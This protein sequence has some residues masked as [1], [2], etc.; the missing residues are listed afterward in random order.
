MKLPKM[1]FQFWEA[2]KRF[3]KL[4]AQL[5]QKE[6]DQLNRSAVE[7]LKKS[8]IM[9]MFLSILLTIFKSLKPS[10]TQ[11]DHEHLVATFVYFIFSSTSIYFISKHPSYVQVYLGFINCTAFIM[12]HVSYV[13]DYVGHQNCY[14]SCSYCSFYFMTALSPSK[15]R[16]NSIVF[17]LTTVL[18]LYLTWRKIGELDNDILLAAIISVSYYNF[19]AHIEQSRLADMY[20]IILKNNKLVKEKAKMMQEF[21]HPVLILPQRISDKSKCYPNNQFEASIK[22]LN[23]K[24]QRLEQVKVTLKTDKTMNNQSEH[25]DLLQFLTENPHCY[26][27]NGQNFRKHAII[28]CDK[29]A[30]NIPVK[31]SNM[32]DEIFDEENRF[33][34]NFEIKSLK[35]EWKGKP[36]IMHVFIDTTDIINLEKAKNRIKM[37][38]VMFASASHE[39]RTPLNAIINSYKI[40]KTSFDEHIKALHGKVPR[41]VLESN[42]VCAH[43]DNILRFIKTGSISS[44]LMMA[45][46]EDIL[47]LSRIDNGTFTT[48]YSYFNVY[49]LLLEICTLFETQCQSR[50]VALLI[51]CDDQVQFCEVNTDRN[52]VRQ[53][54]LNLVSNSVKLTFKGSITLKAKMVKDFGGQSFV[55]F[56]VHDTGPGIKQEDQACLFKLFGVLEDNE[57]LNPDGCGLGL[58]VS[59]K[60]VEGLGGDIK[61]ESVYGEGTEMIFTVLSRDIRALS[62]GAK[63]GIFDLL[64]SAKD[65]IGNCDLSEYLINQEHMPEKSEINECKLFKNNESKF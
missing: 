32:L 40:I 3:K 19:G 59:K 10:R 34:R 27:T 36:S 52:R 31:R 23:R 24:I 60:Y 43:I 37:Q 14:L 57:G 58:T 12:V 11:Q 33:R 20:L 17:A 55:E 21:P 54:L 42:E 2:D 4:E 51:E 48:N 45:L 65:L 26:K 15:R 63:K 62:A 56:R 22:T 29:S 9:L 13:S 1:L 25:C 35:M 50:G 39:F 64:K 53:V 41:D 47:S 18:N 6:I 49:A 7:Y 61:V 44:V 46:V 38:R 8:A 5:P 16:L 28:D 30:D